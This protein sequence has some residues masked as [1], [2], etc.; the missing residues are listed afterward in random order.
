MTAAKFDDHD[1]G[2]FDF[3]RVDVHLQHYIPLA[4]RYRVLAFRAIGAFTNADSGQSVPFYLQPTLGGHRDLRGFRESRFRD[5][6][7]VLLGAE[8][9]GKPG[10]RSMARSSSTPG[11]SR[12]LDGT[13]RSTRWRCP[14]A[15]GSASTAT[16]PWSA[17]SIWRSAGKGSSPPEVRTCLLNVA[18][19]SLLAALATSARSLGTDAAGSR[20]GRASTADDPL[21]HDDDM[22]SIAE[23][24]EHDLSK[25]YEFV[26]NTFGETAR[27]F[28]PAL[29]VN[30]LGEVPDS[31]WFTNRIGQ[32]DMTVDDVLRGPNQVDGPAPGQWLVTG[33]PD[34]G[35]TPKFTIR[36]ARG[37]TYLIKLD[38]ASNPELPSSVE[39][40]ST[41]LFHAIGY[42]VPQDFVVHFRLDDLG[43]RQAHGSATR[44]VIGC[45]SN[46]PTF[47]GGWKRAKAGDGSIRALAS[48]WVPGKVVGQFTF[49]G[50]R[51]DDPNDVFPHE[52][53]ARTARAAAV[54]RLAE[55]RRRPGDQ[56][57][58]HLRRR[59]RA[60]L[61]PPLPA[62][63]RIESG[64]RQ[65][66]GTA[67][68]R[69]L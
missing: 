38:P 1:L 66:L 47:I 45:P 9:D 13:C 49:N 10:G 18:R 44:L 48:L 32:H 11:P 26:A 5:E 60:P 64:Q 15:S 2:Q 30:T 58:R 53:P 28:G 51:S 16:A 37:D 3:Y 29:N 14:T 33:R 31:S 25:S 7:T 34:A 24:A 17:A 57:H 8:Y 59:G 54:C 46:R 41:K 19:V 61:H 36:D 62:G 22:R 21:W 4:S 65:H 55:P 40:I 56:Q 52:A 50:R 68:A 12:L 63:L 67:A 69:R 43:S 35:I 27:S 42:H 23:P 6:N 39:L 20:I